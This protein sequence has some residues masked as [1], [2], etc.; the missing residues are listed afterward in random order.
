MMQDFFNFNFFAFCA[1]RGDKNLFS[2][3]RAE[4]LLNDLTPE[5][6]CGLSTRP[7]ISGATKERQ[8]L[9]GK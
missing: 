7:F 8:I 9:T 2:F 5:I 3:Q 6:K 1:S 4:S